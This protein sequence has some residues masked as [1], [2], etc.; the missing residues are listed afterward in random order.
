M[1]NLLFPLALLF[2]A[3]A[4]NPSNFNSEPL[5]VGER[6]KQAREA[7]NI[8]QQALSDSTDISLDVLNLIE[9]CEATPMHTK[10]KKIEQMLDIKIQ[11]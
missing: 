11:P 4:T 3:C 6:I 9:N 5:C 2:A 1:K 8:S 10:W 7:K